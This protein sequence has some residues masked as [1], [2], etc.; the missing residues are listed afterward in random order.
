MEESIMAYKVISNA[1]VQKRLEELTVV[2]PDL[3]KQGQIAALSALLKGDFSQEGSKQN[4]LDEYK[5]KETQEEIVQKRGDNYDVTATGYYDEL[6]EMAK[7]RYSMTHADEYTVKPLN[8]PE[9]GRL[10]TTVG[11]DSPFDDI[12]LLNSEL[13]AYTGKV[14]FDM[15]TRLGANNFNRYLE[16]E[17]V[18]GKLDTQSVHVLKNKELFQDK[19]VLFD[20][21]AEHPGFVTA[22]GDTYTD[23]T[24]AAVFTKTSAEANELA[25]NDESRYIRIVMPQAILD[26]MPQD[27]EDKDPLA[28]NSSQVLDSTYLKR[29][30]DTNFIVLT[31]YGFYD[32]KYND[33][34]NTS[35]PKIRSFEMDYAN[36]YKPET[37]LEPWILNQ[38][39]AMTPTVIPISDAQQEV[40][41][42]ID[43]FSPEKEPYGFFFEPIGNANKIEKE[44]STLPELGDA[45]DDLQKTEEELDLPW[46]PL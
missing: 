31:E 21:K 19:F 36:L 28:I 40:L 9:Y 30:P 32:E 16:G 44:V 15:T 22:W 1:Q 46:A 33:L 17:M 35:R 5:V 23:I 13:G 4:I 24:Q 42:T 10:V 8:L 12:E 20:M 38:T 25:F 39:S 18:D 41:K 45:L 34:T 43:A 14:L 29:N 27:L 37:L 3:Y 6:V 7:G 26:N 2:E 11:M